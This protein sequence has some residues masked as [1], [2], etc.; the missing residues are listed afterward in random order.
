[1][2]VV[3]RAVA[4]SVMLSLAW[5]GPLAPLALAQAPVTPSEAAP[6]APAPAA[7]GT[8]WQM[9]QEQMK[10]PPEKK[11][12]DAYDVGAVA[13]T[14]FGLPFKVGLCALGMKAMEL[15]AIFGD[16][17]TIEKAG[18]GPGQRIRLGVR[19]KDDQLTLLWIERLR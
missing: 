11:G 1:M 3:F 4:V 12:I 19:Q 14:A 6:P 10:A 15:M 18:A 17:D 9:F 5:A 7:P 13:A 16:P 8:T 2:K